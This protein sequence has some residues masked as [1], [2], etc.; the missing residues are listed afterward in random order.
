MHELDPNDQFLI[1]ASDGLWEHLSNQDAV[2]IVHKHPH[3]VSCVCFLFNLIVIVNC[4]QFSYSKNPPLLY[5]FLHP[6]KCKKAGEGSNA[7]SS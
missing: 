1:F 4:I 3:S 2:D 6:G 5:G 7:G